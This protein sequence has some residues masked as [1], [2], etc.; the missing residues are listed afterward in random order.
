MTV[1]MI[2]LISGA[3]TILNL[4]STSMSVIL[5][6]MAANRMPI[7]MQPLGPLPNGMKAPARVNGGHEID[8]ADCKTYVGHRQ[9][10]H[11]TV[12]YIHNMLTCYTS[13]LF[14]RAFFLALQM[15]SPVI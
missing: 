13:L 15:T 3:L 10:M 5:G 8:K 14:R 7:L 2:A 4:L 12:L 11:L 6:S 9:D 1:Q